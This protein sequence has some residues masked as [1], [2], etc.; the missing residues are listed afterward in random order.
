MGAVN[1]PLNVGFVAKTK[2][3]VPV[4]SDIIPA[5]CADVVDAN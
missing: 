2:D 5:S 3:P 1:V 4:S